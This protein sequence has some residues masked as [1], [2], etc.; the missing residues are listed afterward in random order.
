MDHGHLS[1]AQARSA[2]VLGADRPRLTSLSAVPPVDEAIRAAAYRRLDVLTKPRGALGRLEPLAAQVCAIQGTLDV[3]I[4]QPVGIVFAA[5]HGV[6]ERGVSAYPRE[7]TVQM[8]ANFLH[9][10]A[11]IS[12]LAKLQG[13]DLWI[14]DAG[15]DGEC[16]AHPR[17][18]EAKIRRGTRNF[19]DEPAMTPQECA[20]SLQRGR[21]VVERVMPRGSNALLLGEMGIGNTAAAAMLMHGLT[22]RELIDC[23]GRGT[24][25]DDAGLRRKRQLLAQALERRAAPP[26]PLELLAEFGGFEIAMLAGAVLAGAARRAL[27]LVDGFTATVAAAL[28]ARLDPGVLDY[29]VFGHCSAEHAHRALLEHL[30]VQPLLDLGMRLGEGSGAAVALSVVRAAVALFTDMA[31]FEGAGVSDKDA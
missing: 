21:E 7:V 3:R 15:V 23:V 31:T 4:V 11:A 6:A 29:C 12:V 13:V 22:G 8:V 19:I 9:G 5:D 10:G 17:L 27:I 1:F 14:V 20:D 26:D 24:G 30:R 16:M 18:I 28:A 2:F 25:L